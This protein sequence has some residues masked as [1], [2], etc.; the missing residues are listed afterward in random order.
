MVYYRQSIRAGVR[1]AAGILTGAP[2]W[3]EEAGAFVKAAKNQKDK[4]RRA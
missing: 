4:I 2:E 3:Y 1:R